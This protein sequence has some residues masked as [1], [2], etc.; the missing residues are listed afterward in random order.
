MNYR[1]IC[2]I[3]EEGVT[4]KIRTSEDFFETLKS[5]PEGIHID[6]IEFELRDLL[7][8][9][10]FSPDKSETPLTEV[11]FFL[12]QYGDLETEPPIKRENEFKNKYGWTNVILIDSSC[13]IYH[14]LI[15]NGYQHTGNYLSK[16]RY[17]NPR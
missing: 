11:D 15:E 13:D 10:H 17:T 4:A 2:E 12:F 5:L 3:E 7:R 6:E 16:H 1:E 14:L 8:N 9:M